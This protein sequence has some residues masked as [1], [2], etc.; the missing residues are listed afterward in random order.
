MD[1]CIDAVNNRANVFRFITVINIFHIH[2]L[3]FA[4]ATAD[5]WIILYRGRVVAD[6][7]PQDLIIDEELIRLGALPEPEGSRQ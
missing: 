4:Q 2:D 3:D 5:R 7:S 6:G 1:L